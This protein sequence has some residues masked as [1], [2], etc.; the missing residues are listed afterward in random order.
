VRVSRRPARRRKPPRQ[1]LRV[2]VRDADG[3]RPAVT[4]ELRPRRR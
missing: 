4:L 2:L 3:L 1:A